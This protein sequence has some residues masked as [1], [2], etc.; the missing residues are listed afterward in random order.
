[1]KQNIIISL[2]AALALCGCGDKQSSTSSPSKAAASKQTPPPAEFQKA[3]LQVAFGDV[4]PQRV[5]MTVEEMVKPFIDKGVGTWS[6]LSETE[7]M[8][9]LSTEDNVTNK[10]TNMK[11]VFDKQAR[12]NGDV[13]FKRLV[14]EGQDAT[15][16][17][18]VNFVT[19]M[20]QNKQ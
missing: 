11:L 19:A 3:Q 13:L 4:A 14:A 12:L 17:Q 10:K 16:L 20:K 6:K 7:F 18:I 8:L 15:E 1:M 2:F 9:D 5:E